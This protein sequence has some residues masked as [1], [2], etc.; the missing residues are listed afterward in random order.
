MFV[1]KVPSSDEKFPIHIS[2]ADTN[3][4]NIYFGV[5]HMHDDIEVIYVIDGSVEF[6]I[7]DK[8]VVVNAGQI[9][10]INGLVVHSTYEA[11][12][13]YTK[14][15]M[16]QFN[17]NII[18]SHLIYINN[19]LV[20]FIHRSDFKY[21]VL[22]VDENEINKEI[23]RIIL[24]VHDEFSQKKVAYGLAILSLL[25]DFFRIL[26]RENIIKDYLNL[27]DKFNTDSL[28]KIVG[29]IKYIEKNYSQEIYITDVAEV[30][31][32]TQS[33]FCRLFKQA[34]GKTFV[35]F[36]NYYRITMAKNLLL[37]SN[38][39]ITEIMIDCGFKSYSYFNRIFKSENGLS[40]TEYKK[41]L[42]DI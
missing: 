12:H 30:L 34:T 36:L 7:E 2:I 19:L 3:D 35:Q 9:I 22:T 28:V 13:K 29:A 21:S 11:R 14:M 31:E 1:E 32:F 17:L 18:Y 41:L 42:V 24:S 27:P 6:Y 37:S 4:Y 16:M 39:S 25:Y 5:P 10:I 26:F 8:T 20:N 23:A 33:H 40:P 38:K 15:C